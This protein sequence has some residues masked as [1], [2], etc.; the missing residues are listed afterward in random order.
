MKNDSILLAIGSLFYLLGIIV[1]VSLNNISGL[2][3]AA[4]LG[5][6]GCVCVFLG[7]KAKKTQKEEFYSSLVEKIVIQ[8]SESA[9]NL[10]KE[11]SQTT[12]EISSLSELTNKNIAAIESLKTVMDQN[13]VGIEATNNEIK[14][15]A[16]ALASLEESTKV[17]VA[18]GVEQLVQNVKVISSEAQKQQVELQGV[19]KATN[20][21]LSATQERISKETGKVGDLLEQNNKQ[22]LEVA[23]SISN[24]NDIPSEVLKTFD[25]I[26]EEIKDIQEEQRNIIEELVDDIR[27]E[28][29]DVSRDMRR[30]VT[31]IS[32]DFDAA[33]QVMQAE[34]QK[35]SEQYASFEQYSDAVVD[36]LTLMSKN[37]I[38]TMRKFVNGK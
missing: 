27:D 22:V 37:D 17:S 21:E 13:V 14:K 9:D 26:I 34:I 1:A 16:T 31:K 38:E 32:E 6:L 12:S 20:V 4:V 24:L 36:K 10:K 15:I 11:I 23:K 5:L 25:E 18:E 28:N 7:L 19:V 33:T 2:G 35:L 8:N 29:N 30:T 3:G